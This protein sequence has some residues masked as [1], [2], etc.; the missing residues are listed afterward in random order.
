MIH[1]PEQLEYRPLSVW[2]YRHQAPNKHLALE[3][4]IG[5]GVIVVQGGN[6]RNYSSE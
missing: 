6:L 1:A 4:N 3:I 2:G 5:F